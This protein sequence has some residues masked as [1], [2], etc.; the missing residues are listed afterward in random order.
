MT[1]GKECSS[2]EK[3][4]IPSTIGDDHIVKKPGFDLTEASTAI[5]D[6]SLTSLLVGDFFVILNCKPDIILLGRPLES[7]FCVISFKDNC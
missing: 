7:S 2:R 6:L 3:L 5:T 4:S 1:S